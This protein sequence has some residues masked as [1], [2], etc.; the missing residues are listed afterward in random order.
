LA[1]YRD[2]SVKY[3]FS[4]EKDSKDSVGMPGRVFLGKVPEWT[5]DVRFFR[6]DEYPRVNHAQQCDVRGTLAL[7]VFEQGS[8]TCLGVIE[9]V[10]TSQKIKYLPELESVC[11]ALE[12]CFSFSK[13][14][15]AS[16]FTSSVLQP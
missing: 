9:V 11:K 2:I 12:V 1:S 7:P 15:S 13:C 16:Q 6:N 10:T 4:A 5:P 3:Q 14:F 8:R